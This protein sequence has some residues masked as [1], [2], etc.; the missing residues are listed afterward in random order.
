MGRMKK[1]NVVYILMLMMLV[2]SGCQE[3]AV[4]LENLE[5]E[6]YEVYYAFDEYT[7]YKRSIIEEQVYLMYA[8]II[9]D[10]DDSCTIG[11]YH[12]VNFMVFHNDEYYGIQEFNKTGMY[13]CGALLKSGF[14]N[15]GVHNNENE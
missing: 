14:L 9:G 6:N 1:I 3:K 4:P 10:E 5:L 13:D 11:N 2:L 8:F 15:E 12:E 7:I